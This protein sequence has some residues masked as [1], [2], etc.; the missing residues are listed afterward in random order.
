V[1][2]ANFERILRKEGVEFLL[3][4]KVDDLIIEENTCTGVVLNDGT[5]ISSLFTII[6]PGRVGAKWID[7]IL[8]KHNIEAKYAPLMLV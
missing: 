1:V 3:D 7:E 8:H 6:A 2:I 4:T 5:R